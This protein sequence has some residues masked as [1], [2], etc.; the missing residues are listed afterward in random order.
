MS[1]TKKGIH[2]AKKIVDFLGIEEIV[3]SAYY[4]EKGVF[5]HTPNKFP[6]ILLDAWGYIILKTKKDLKNLGETD[7][8]NKYLSDKRLSFEKGSSLGDCVLSGYVFNTEVQEITK[9]ESR[10]STCN[11]K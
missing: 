7:E 3:K 9:R 8:I 6:A 5:Y 2:S 1:K 4:S 10:R 11:Y